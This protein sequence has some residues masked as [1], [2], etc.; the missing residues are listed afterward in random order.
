MSFIGAAILGGSAITAGAGLI[1]D[2]M[3]GGQ[4]EIQ[5]VYTQGPGYGTSQ[6]IENNWAN[7]LNGANAG[8][9][10]NSISPDWM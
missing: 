7:F 5:D 6:G 1:G 10:Y 3:N 2:A 4:P 9:N 8:N